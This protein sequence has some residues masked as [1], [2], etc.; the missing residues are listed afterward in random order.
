MV[1]EPRQ[2][3]DLQKRELTQLIEKALGSVSEK[4][5]QVLELYYV[6]DL[7]VRDITLTL[8]LNEG[9]VKARLFRGR[10]EMRKQHQAR[11]QA[12]S[13]PERP[14]SLPALS[15]RCPKYD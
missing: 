6:A 8:G 13:T 11:L 5:R 1:S 2:H 3:A 4:Y 12:M 7:K 14:F 15:I 9:A 10:E